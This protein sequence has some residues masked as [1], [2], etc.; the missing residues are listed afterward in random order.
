MEY[1]LEERLKD[2]IVSCQSNINITEINEKTNLVKDFNFTSVD[3]IQLVVK[4][5]SSFSIELDDENLQIEKL[6]SYKS[7]LDIMQQKLNGD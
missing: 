6:S 2:I 1:S 5:E 4:L 7:L 3:I